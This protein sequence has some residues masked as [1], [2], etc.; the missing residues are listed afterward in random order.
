MMKH[1]IWNPYN[2]KNSISQYKLL[3]LLSHKNK[4]DFL[5]IAHDHL[6]MTTVLQTMW[7]Q[8]NSIYIRIFFF[9][10]KIYMEMK[11]EKAF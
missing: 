3:G 4:W 2:W 10:K 11:F 1:I 8:E 9:Q 6:F 5:L 7:S